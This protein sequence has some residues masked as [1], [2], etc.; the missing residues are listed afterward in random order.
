MIFPTLVTSKGVRGN[1][2][3]ARILSRTYVDF[4]NVVETWYR[5][6]AERE[7]YDSYR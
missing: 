6:L 5:T 3:T 4:V 7:N 1:M 2:K